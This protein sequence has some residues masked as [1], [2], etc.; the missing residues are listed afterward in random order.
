MSSLGLCK[1]ALRQFYIIYMMVID[2][3]ICLHAAFGKEDNSFFLKEGCIEHCPWVLV[4]SID[5]DIRYIR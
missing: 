1:E 5:L 2:V 4:F 3:L